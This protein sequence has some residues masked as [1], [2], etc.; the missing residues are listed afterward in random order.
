MATI[1]KRSVDAAKAGEKDAYLWDK[2]LKGFGLK[3]TPG[4]SEGLSRA[5]SPR[6]PEGPHPPGHHRLAWRPHRR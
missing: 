4:G 3:V 2:D 6:R 5:I 1:S